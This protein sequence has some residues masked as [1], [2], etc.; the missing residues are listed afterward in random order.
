MKHLFSFSILVLLLFSCSREKTDYLGPSYISAPQGFGVTSFTAT[1]SPVDFT[2]NPV[3]LN[4]TFTN[5]VSWTLTIRGQ[6]SGAIFERKG[7]SN[8]LS[9]EEWT[10]THDGIFFF[11]KGETAIAT[12]SFFG[13]D[14]TYSVP[15]IITKPRNFASYG[16][17]PLVGD[18]ENPLLVEPQPPA[19]SPY[20]ASFNYPTAIPNVVQG[21][22]SVAI[23]YQG[24]SVPS[25]EGSK[26]YYIKGKG[27][28]QVFV[29]GIQYF[30]ALTPVL[31]ATPDN[32]WVNMYVYGTGDKNTAIELEYQ[33]SD[34]DG[35]PGYQ[36]Y[37]DDA[38]VA[39]INIEHKGW[40]LFSFKYSSLYPSLNADF[41][42]SGNKIHEPNRLRSFVMVLLKR[43]NPD[44]P[45]E[46]YVDYPIITVG[47]PFNPSK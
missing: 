5:S 40:K 37:D 17:F 12:L 4:A 13:T 18:F 22:D 43:S 38:F 29:S 39:H 16:Q 19:Y 10:G 23:D 2:V 27:D 15:V 32:I 46:V 20:W 42:G 8:G 6:K 35:Y 3:L 1:P 33:E 26:Y 44:A 25:V 45:V 28:Q 41:G 36:G 11:R 34:I 24:N 14:L 31:P 30:G 21:V 7:I 9:N 47:G